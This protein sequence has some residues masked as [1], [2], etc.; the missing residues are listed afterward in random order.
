[1]DTMFKLSI[2]I[3]NTSAYDKDDKHN[4]LIQQTKPAAKYF[5]ETYS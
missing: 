1:M 5:I 4:Y 2:Y 3:A